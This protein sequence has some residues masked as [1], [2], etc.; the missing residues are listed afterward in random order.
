[1]RKKFVFVITM[2]AIVFF[3]PNAL[4]GTQQSEDTRGFAEQ[5]E[6]DVREFGFPEYQFDIV[7][8]DEKRVSARLQIKYT[9]N[10][11]YPMDDIKMILPANALSG[12]EHI[13]LK[14]LEV[15]DRSFTYQKNYQDITLSLVKSLMPGETLEIKADF[16]TILPCSP[17]KF[18]YYQGTIRLSNWYPVVAPVDKKE[19]KWASF[20]PLEFGDP[21]YYEA[22]LFHGTVKVPG[23]RQVISPFVPGKKQG[24]S[25]NNYIIDSVYPARDC[26]FVIGTGFRE[27]SQ[28][29][30]GIHVE[31]YFQNEDRGFAAYGKDV[32]EYYLS[33]LGSYPYSRLVLVDLP[34]SN[35]FGMEFSGMVFLS[36]SYCVGLKTIAHEIAHQYWYGLV[37]S[38]QI[39]EPWID[40]GLA[41][42]CALIYL[43]KK[44]GSEAYCQAIKE[45]KP[46]R[47]Y[48]S[49][50]PVSAYPEKEIYKEAV[51]ARP[52]LFWDRLRS[53]AGTEGLSQGFK[54]AQ[55]DYRFQVMSGE[56]LFCILKKEYR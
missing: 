33:L 10:Q 52:A 22:A 19:N 4:W 21:Y 51:Y 15:V 48:L 12:E 34:L 37:G 42:Y 24:L 38:D 29:V 5:E 11:S 8:H 44:H 20:E 43:E 17:D 54:K 3:Y 55:T 36:T 18:G 16:D 41:N 1:M 30:G 26:T 35:Y 23:D 6:S 14:E 13:K 56:D 39:K 47:K 28:R 25:K 45:I 50:L 9:N 49:F 46:E 2:L 31:Y 32:L 53:L 27:V 40:E 7:V